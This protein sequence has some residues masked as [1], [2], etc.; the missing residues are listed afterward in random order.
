MQVDK[1]LFT[2]GGLVKMIQSEV[3]ALIIK[4]CDFEYKP[5]KGPFQLIEKVEWYKKHVADIK[6]IAEQAD[7]EKPTFLIPA[8]IDLNPTSF[9]CLGSCPSCMQ[10]IGPGGIGN[11]SLQ[12]P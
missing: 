6:A 3:L 12:E 4:T 10:K 11:G 1:L 2:P 9:L 7:K 5:P 8:G